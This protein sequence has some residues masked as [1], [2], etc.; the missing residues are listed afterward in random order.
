M[1]RS[2]IKYLEEAEAQAASVPEDKIAT[3]ISEK[4]KFSNPLTDFVIGLVKPIAKPL[5]DELDPKKRNSTKDQ[6]AQLD[7]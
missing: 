2:I 3:N 1:S 5:T 7:N 4:K 6:F